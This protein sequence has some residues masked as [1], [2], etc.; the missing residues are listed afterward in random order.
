M[1]VKWKMFYLFSPWT[2][3][4]YFTYQDKWL[5]YEPQKEMITVAAD[6]VIQHRHGYLIHWTVSFAC[7]FRAHAFPALGWIRVAPVQCNNLPSK[8]SSDRLV[9]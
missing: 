8:R 2:H 3:Q 9:C 5:L 1:L 7:T 4:A 6:L